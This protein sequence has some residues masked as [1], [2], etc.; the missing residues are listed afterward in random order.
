MELRPYQLEALDAI[1]DALMAKPDVLLQAATGGGK[2]IMFSHLI[3]RLLTSFP[4]MRIAVLAHR[5]ELVRQACDKLLS[6]WPEA[7]RNVGVACAGLGEVTTDRPVVIGTVQTLARRVAYRPYNLMIVDE[8]HRVAPRNDDSPSQYQKL[9]DTCRRRRP[10]MRLLG[11]TATPYRL[12]HGLIYG[13]KNDWFDSL[14]YQISLDDLIEAN[15]LVPLKYKVI[16]DI[17]DEERNKIKIDRGE[18]KNDQLEDLMCKEYHLDSIVST[19]KQYGEDRQHCCI[20]ACSIKHAEAVKKILLNY[21]YK[22]DA[23]HSDL[24]DKERDNIIKNFERGD[25][26]FIIN[27]GILTEGW[28]SPH[29]DIIIMARP[30]LSPSLYVQMIGRGTRILDNKENLLVLDMV[31]N[32]LLHGSPSDPIIHASNEAIN[33]SYKACPECNSPVNNYATT[34]PC[35]GYVWEKIID[36]KDIVIVDKGVENLISVDVS[37]N[38]I[39]STVLHWDGAEYVSSKNNLMFKLML[40]C[41]PGGTV[42]T[43]LDFEGNGS[44]YGKVKAK[45]LWRKI[46][47][48]EP[49]ETVNEA[50]ER[51]NELVIPETVKLYKDNKYLRVAGW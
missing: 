46:A 37:R 44:L 20:F 43:Y 1:W 28:D 47:K 40:Q 19:Y 27:V 50:V 6:V 39:V 16:E 3:Q 33:K 22:A 51:I 13:G 32:Y 31:G 34:C 11:V 49:P 21:G 48:T 36:E 23:V 18:Y 29:I 8:I 24:P 9:I 12:N 10:S 45:Q 35:C 7:V 5:K 42:N 2:T 14:D 41:R 25:L 17:S 38:N 15:Y 30:T 4:K 26:N